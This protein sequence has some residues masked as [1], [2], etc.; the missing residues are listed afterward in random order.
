MWI[1][2]HYNF[3]KIHYY[4]KSLTTRTI[5]ENVSF[6]AFCLYW[7]FTWQTNTEYRWINFV[8]RSIGE[9]NVRNVVIKASLNAKIN[10]ILLEISKWNYV[11]SKHSMKWFGF[12]YALRIHM[13]KLE[14][15]KMA[16]STNELVSKNE[17]SKCML[18]FNVCSQSTQYVT[19]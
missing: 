16:L 5:K 7:S 1:N 11:S 18:S 13:Q 10:K 17:P 4:V 3:V 8:I 15:T 19:S 6:A 12:I 9:M 2:K 14:A